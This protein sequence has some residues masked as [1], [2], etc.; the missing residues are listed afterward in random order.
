MNESP[1]GPLP[2][3]P[4]LNRNRKFYADLRDRSYEESFYQ[5][6]EVVKMVQSVN[7]NPEVNPLV[8]VRDLIATLTDCHAYAEAALFG[9]NRKTRS[10]EALP[11]QV[12]PEETAFAAL[13]HD[14][15]GAAVYMAAH[16]DTN[17][18]LWQFVD[19]SESYAPFCEV[20]AARYKLANK[21]FGAI[22]GHS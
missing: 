1:T 8:A 14:L 12:A 7:P 17:Q 20:L 2:A 16:I 19:P 22:Q 3:L 9:H 21:L 13:V 10:A 15:L 11:L 4:P 5:F 6:H 18:L